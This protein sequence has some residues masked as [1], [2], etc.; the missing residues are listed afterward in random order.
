MP[1]AFVTG[2]TGLLGNNLVR[3]L[4]ANGYTVRALARSPEK[5]SMQFNDLSPSHRDA[6]TVV[7]GDLQDVAGFADALEGVELL[8][9]TAAYFRDAY[10]G[11]SHGT[12]LHD[13]N[14]S[15]SQALLAAA[16]THGVR[17][18]VY[19]SSIAVLDG[20]RGALIDEGMDRQVGDADDYYASKIAAERAVD[21]FR[22]AHP[23]FSVS[24]VLPAWMFGPGDLGPT[25]AGQAIL[26][27]AAGRIP[28]VLPGSFS[29][30]DARDVAAAHLAAALRG[31]SGERYLAAG[32]HMTM[33][34]LLPLMSRATGKPAPSRSLPYAL[35]YLVGAM[36]E[37]R[38]RV[39]KT[40]VLLGLATVR[41]LRREEE[42][43][44]YSA[45]K[46][47]AELGVHFRPVMETLMDTVADYRERGLLAN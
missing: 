4:L 13:V 3:L 40:P 41:V 18:A 34:D 32:H 1:L 22:R 47:L 36:N 38:Y 15:G 17:R 43:S 23:D 35:L 9:H 21:A 8:F 33:G 5:A 31:R 42:R 39:T 19:T 10:K 12:A 25:S 11:G 6:L 45:A 27:F 46:T 20:P 7:R 29:V 44:R 26:D 28:G 37:L 30:V 14:V 2:S 16:Y 24:Y